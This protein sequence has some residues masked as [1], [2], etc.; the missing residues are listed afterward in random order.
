MYAKIQDVKSLLLYLFYFNENYIECV[1][2]SAQNFPTLHFVRISLEV[3]ELLHA[4][5]H[6]EVNTCIFVSF[7]LFTATCNLNKREGKTV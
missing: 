3:L 5:R 1:D 2:K 6:G 4:D 7:L